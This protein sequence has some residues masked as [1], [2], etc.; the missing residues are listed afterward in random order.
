MLL[1]DLME[2]EIPDII[3]EIREHLPKIYDYLLEEEKKESI[4]S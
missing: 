2:Y 3:D 1:A 4:K